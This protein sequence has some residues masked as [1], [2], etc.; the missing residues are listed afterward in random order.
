MSN[1]LKVTIL[2][3]FTEEQLAGFKE[4]SNGNLKGPC[5]CCGKQDNYSGFTIF[6]N[7]NTAY[8]HGSKTI[9]SM[10]E[11]IGLLHGVFSCREGR[12]KI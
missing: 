8:C 6:I 11:M 5:P 1:P 2:D 4:D 9:F 12:Q 3:L 10:K 7:S